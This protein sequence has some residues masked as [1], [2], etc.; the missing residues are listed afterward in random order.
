MLG[1]ENI[2][3][4]SKWQNELSRQQLQIDPLSVH[5]VRAYPPAIFNRFGYVAAIDKEQRLWRKNS[6]MRDYFFFGINFIARP[7]KS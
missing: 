6:L 2:R 4:L 5:Y 7:I 1:N 3:S